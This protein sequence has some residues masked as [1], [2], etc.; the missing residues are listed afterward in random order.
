M[1]TKMLVT[2]WRETVSKNFA[3]I[4]DLKEVSRQLSMKEG[5][6]VMTR[7]GKE[8]RDLLMGSLDTVPS[9]LISARQRKVEYGELQE[10]SL[11]VGKL[12]D[13]KEKMSAAH[14]D[15]SSSVFV[16]QENKKV[17]SCWSK[18]SSEIAALFENCSIVMRK[19][20]ILAH[21]SGMSKLM[22]NLHNSLDK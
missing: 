20:P 21:F 5:Q 2:D 1:S 10:L 12:E 22:A 16:T 13:L 11:A 15:S 17:V 18:S 14:L 4:N 7:S 19:H 3:K 8:W 9:C 6:L